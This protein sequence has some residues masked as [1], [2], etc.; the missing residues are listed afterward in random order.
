M[1]GQSGLKDRQEQEMLDSASCEQSIARMAVR[2]F[3]TLIHKAGGIK[4]VKGMRPIEPTNL[5]MPLKQSAR[6]S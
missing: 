4:N 6:S 2:V 3:L 1:C 5:H